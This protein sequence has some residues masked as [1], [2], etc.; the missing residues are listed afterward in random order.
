MGS[1]NNMYYYF[2]HDFNLNI[3]NMRKIKKFVLHEREIILSPEEMRLVNGGGTP[4]CLSVS[5]SVYDAETHEL[6][7]SGTCGSGVDSK[8]HPVCSCNTSGGNFP[9]EGACDDN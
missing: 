5:C 8:G 7:Y 6:L 1:K 4:G 3:K 2:I 9:G